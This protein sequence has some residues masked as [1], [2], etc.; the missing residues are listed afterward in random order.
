MT[1]EQAIVLLRY[2][3]A[4]ISG[5]DEAL[6]AEQQRAA[7]VVT[8]IGFDAKPPPSTTCF[9]DWREQSRIRDALSLVA[10]NDQARRALRTV[11]Y[12]VLHQAD[13]IGLL[14]RE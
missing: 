9:D 5:I 11:E 3:M 14:G 10:A 12:K 1:R 6:A 8:R 7:S 2:A 4:A 13:A